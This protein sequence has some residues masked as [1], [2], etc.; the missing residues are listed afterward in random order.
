MGEERADPP[1]VLL[2][3]LALALLTLPLAAGPVLAAEPVEQWQ[4]TFSGRIVDVDVTPSGRTAVATSDGLTTFTDDKGK[5]LKQVSGNT[6]AVDV[7]SDGLKVVVAGPSA[8]SLVSNAGTTLWTKPL[9]GVTTAVGMGP[10]G[11]LVAAGADDKAVYLFDSS[12]AQLAK[13]AVGEIPSGVA[14]A[15]DKVAVGLPSGKVLLLDRQGTVLI[16]IA[17]GAPVHAVDLSSA[18]IAAATESNLA[19]FSHA[20]ERLWTG[21]LGSAARAVAVSADGGLTLAAAQAGDVALYN[22]KGEFLWKLKKSGEVFTAVGLS[23]GGSLA[24]IGSRETF[25]RMYKTNVS[26]A[27]PEGSAAAT[28]TPV[29]TATPRPTPTPQAESLLLDQPVGT[30]FRAVTL[31]AGRAAPAWSKPQVKI[32]GSS[33]AV[34]GAAISPDGATIAVVTSPTQTSK[35][36]YYQDSSGNSAGSPTTVLLTAA[37]VKILQ[38]EFSSDSQRLLLSVATRLG[39]GSPVCDTAGPQNDAL[40]VSRGSFLWRNSSTSLAIC[41]PGIRVAADAKTAVALAMNGSYAWW[42]DSRLNL[43]VRNNAT[44]NTSLAGAK[45]FDVSP[46]GKLLAVA[47]GNKTIE[48]Y[49][50]TNRTAKVDQLL[51][52]VDDLRFSPDGKLVVRA[53]PGVIFLDPNTLQADNT[54]AVHWQR[55]A[56]G[57]LSW[58]VGKDAFA[59]GTKNTKE[60]IWSRGGKDIVATTVA[61]EVSTV[62][63]SSNGKFLAAGSRQAFKVWLFSDD[64]TQLWEADLSDVS[65]VSVSDGGSVVA[66]TNTGAD[67]SSSVGHIHYFPL[68]VLDIDSSPSGGRVA[69]D[70]VD[71]GTTPVRIQ[72]M[73]PGN[74]TVKVSLAGYRDCGGTV[75]VS[76][77]T[78]RLCKFAPLIGTSPPPETPAPSPSPEATSPSP[79]A[80][81]ATPTPTPAPAVPVPVAPSPTPTPLKSP[82]FEALAALGALAVA[83]SFRKRRT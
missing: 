41:S 75:N 74:H 27:M 83:V 13:R 1:R 7:T 50:D 40:H 80:A 70:G 58:A 72:G 26:E 65:G 61:G 69:L 32:S 22:A 15:G 3:G 30:P 28:P 29:A 60:I 12:G 25:L 2:T 77:P 68:P 59:A 36:L 55:R 24:A 46:D 33:G 66:F 51:F 54:L 20:G 9:G 23:A 79:A 71:S 8:V 16:E 45:V 73:K 39:G 76:G 52:N 48:L 78:Q 67:V 35:E 5:Q 17:A 49:N 19:V 62:A 31:A 64:G 81:A 37:D 47:F 57:V 6:P 44:L 63:L 18:T 21:N 4:Q 14:V 10:D 11:S 34:A 38:M 53:G 82:G 43:R 42:L 56:E